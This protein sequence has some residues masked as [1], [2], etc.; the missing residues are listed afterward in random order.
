[1]MAAARWGEDERAELARLQKEHA[2][3]AMERYVLKRSVALT[4]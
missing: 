4:G 2:E 3:L 1:M